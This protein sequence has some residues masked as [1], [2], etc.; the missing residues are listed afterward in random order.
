VPTSNSDNN[1]TL[2]DAE[3]LTPFF[4]SVTASNHYMITIDLTYSC[5]Y[6][7]ALGGD[8]KFDFNLS[9]GSMYGGGTVQHLNQSNSPVITG[10]IANG[11]S[12]TSTNIINMGAN[13][14][15]GLDYP[16]FARIGY[17]FTPDT[18]G[19]IYFRWA[20]VDTGSAYSRIWAGSVFKYKQLD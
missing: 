6:T 1:G 16:A 15:A 20:H 10:I 9:S 3:A 18:T 12:P 14:A 17:S 5:E 8:I 4:F 11:P 7:S 19:T 2:A 13:A